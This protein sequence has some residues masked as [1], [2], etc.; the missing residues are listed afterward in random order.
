MQPGHLWA[1]VQR[2]SPPSEP[3][4]LTRE[5]AKLNP[6]ALLL[7][8]RELYDRALVGIT[9]APAD[10]WPRSQH[11]RVF[12]A[13]YSRERCIELIMEEGDEDHAEAIEYFEFNTSGAWCGPGTPTFVSEEIASLASPANA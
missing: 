9:D 13:V 4:E 2:S 1:H 3:A 8:P 10:H 6:D 11:A 12:V 5:L 7:E